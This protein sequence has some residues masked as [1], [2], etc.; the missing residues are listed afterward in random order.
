MRYSL[1]NM[2]LTVSQVVEADRLDCQYPFWASC[3]GLGRL[4]KGL[5]TVLFTWTT[6]HREL[7]H[8]F[9]MEEVTQAYH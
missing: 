4:S 1:F 2:Q 6:G 9:R 7:K 5:Y 8:N 3:F